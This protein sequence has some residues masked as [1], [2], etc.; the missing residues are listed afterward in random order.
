M[1]AA[2]FL[3]A[4][5]PLHNKSVRASIY[6]SFWLG[7]FAPTRL[8]LPLTP[9][10]PMLRG[11][12]ESLWLK[13]CET[14]QEIRFITTDNITADSFMLFSV[15]AL[16]DHS[17]ARLGLDQGADC[18]SWTRQQHLSQE[19]SGCPHPVGVFVLSDPSR[20]VPS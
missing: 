15:P 14:Y 11:R 1:I 5:P 20:A 10:P 7:T 8:G 12:R 16:P 17:P 13:H 19:I 9:T 2:C 3:H 18:V 6:R 4:K